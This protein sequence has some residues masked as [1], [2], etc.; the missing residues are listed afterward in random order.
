MYLA[1]KQGC[2]Y[3]LTMDCDEFYEEQ[4][5]KKAKEFIV[6]NNIKSCVVPMVEYIKEPIYQ[7]STDNYCPFIFKINFFSS[8][9]KVKNFPLNVDGSRCVNTKKN[10]YKFSE[11]EIY[12]HHMRLVRQDL[13]AKYINRSNANKFSENT[14]NNILKEVNNYTYPNDFI[15]YEKDGRVDKVSKV[16]N[17][18]NIKI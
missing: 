3:F 11:N 10:F 6:Q 9:K 8:L 5:F 13:K 14:I 2:N 1:K 17:I 18:F 7:I 16:D 12:T 4:Q 15:D